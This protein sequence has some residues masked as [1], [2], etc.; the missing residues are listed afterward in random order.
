[1][2]MLGLINYF[3]LRGFWSTIEKGQKNEA[4]QTQRSTNSYPPFRNNDFP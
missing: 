4:K 2:N 1:M 3:I